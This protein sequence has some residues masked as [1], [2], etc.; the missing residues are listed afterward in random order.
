MAEIMI[1]LNM[2]NIIRNPS[3]LKIVLTFFKSGIC[4]KNIP[5][6]RKKSTAIPK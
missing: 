1:I 3:L 4:E 6:V 5:C 2:S